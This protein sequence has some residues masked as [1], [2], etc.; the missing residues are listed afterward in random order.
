MKPLIVL[1]LLAA[2]PTSAQIPAASVGPD[3]IPGATREEKLF[4]IKD[5]LRRMDVNGDKR[6][7]VDEWT[8]AGGAKAGF[9]ALD[10][11]RDG[12]LTV[13]ELRSNAGKLRAFEDYKAAP[14]H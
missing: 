14:P 6:L 3:T 11:N 10:H 7:T 5:Q 2:V 4:F 9:D 13:Q 12:I 1:L 8:A